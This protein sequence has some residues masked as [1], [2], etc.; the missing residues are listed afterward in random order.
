MNGTSQ[1]FNALLG[2]MNL[3]ILLFPPEKNHNRIDDLKTD[4]DVRTFAMET[5][6]DYGDFTLWSTETLLKNAHCKESFENAG[7]KSWKKVDLNNDGLTDLLMIVDKHPENQQIALL[8][9][10]DNTYDLK[11]VIWNMQDCEFVKPIEFEGKNYLQINRFKSSPY[12]RTSTDTAKYFVDTLTYKFD[13]FVELNSTKTR[14]GD[15]ASVSFRTI[16]CHG[17][18]PVFNLEI[19]KEGKMNF[20]GICFTNY[21]GKSSDIISRK[22]R[23]RIFELLNYIEPM[24]LKR[25]YT[26][27]WSDD[28][29][30]LTTIVFKDGSSRTIDDYGM[31]GTFGLMSLYDKVIAIAAETDWKKSN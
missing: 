31:V 3:I 30:M 29:E 24:R 17:E 1:I 9:K 19:S 22:K 15:I 5:F 18:C 11:I 16:G 12:D 20:E 7:L 26:V 14:R 23:K 6:P 28:S 8:S 10:D 13:S 27:P 4:E 2:L 25:N 21:I